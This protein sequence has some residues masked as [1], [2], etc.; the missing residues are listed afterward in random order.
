MKSNSIDYEIIEKYS[1]LKMIPIECGW[2][3]LGTWKSVWSSLLSQKISQTKC[4][5]IDCSSNVMINNSNKPLV[6][7]GLNNTLVIQTK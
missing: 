4:K 2:S 3:D 6:T 5:E 1:D 7:I